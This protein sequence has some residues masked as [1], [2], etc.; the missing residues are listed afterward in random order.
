MRA[1]LRRLRGLGLLLLAF[2]PP[3]VVVGG[4]AVAVKLTADVVGTT[5][6][7]VQAVADT[8]SGQITPQLQA[9]RATY[10]G[11]ATEAERLES[12]FLRYVPPR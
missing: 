6:G 12:L 2:G 8:I 5:R 3:V 7:E 1:V 4:I 9:I 11:L 10:D